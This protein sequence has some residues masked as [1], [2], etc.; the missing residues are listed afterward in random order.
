MAKAVAAPKTGAKAGPK[1]AK[2]AG[3]A[4]APAKAAAK[5][6]KAAKPAPAAASSGAD[7]AIT[8]SKVCQAFAK[9]AD[10]LAAAVKAAGFSASVDAQPA[11]GRNP[12][13]GT[14]AV[15]VKGGAPL[16]SLVAMPRPFTAMKALD[17]DDV[18]KKVLAALKA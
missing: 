15:S 17:M 2:A 9:R 5:P 3:G 10:A 14:F 18:A 11:L 1:A 12:D 8:S 4:A 13:R 16:V 6:A 7:V